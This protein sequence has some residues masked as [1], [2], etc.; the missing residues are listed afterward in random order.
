MRGTSRFGIPGVAATALLLLATP[1]ARAGGS[2]V[3]V[4]GATLWM[5]V[6]GSGSGTPL[7]VVNGGPGFAHDYMTPADETWN[8]L[9]THR[10]VIFYDQ[11]GVGG[12]PAL[13]RNQSCTLG[14]QIE[15]LDALRRSLGVDRVD[16]LGHS[17]GGYIVMA[18]GARHPEH[19][20]HL[21]ICDSAAPKW[22]DTEFMFKNFYPDV[23][24]REDGYGFAEALGDTAAE[25]ADVREYTTMLFY[26]PEN[27]DRY[28]QHASHFRFDMKVNKRLND[29][30]ARYDLNPEL[31]KFRFPTLVMCGRYD[32]NVA[33]STAWKIY[34]A[35]PGAQVHIFE[36]SGH[37]PWYEEPEAFLNT[38][39]TFLGGS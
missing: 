10:R 28:M 14:D 4:P 24:A 8:R 13:T 9:A 15:D 31:P 29:D 27:R 39:E 35:I 22:G 38:V 23:V 32:T 19:I 3:K 33:P 34:K 21:L 12:S 11:R 37:L 30:L 16:L 25:K 20:A 5:E 1:S 26:S 7:I 17:W 6:R 36:H 18:Y 2:L